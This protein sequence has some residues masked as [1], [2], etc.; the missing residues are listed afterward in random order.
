MVTR[1]QSAQVERWR[2][3]VALSE[4]QLVFRNHRAPDVL[5]QGV[6]EEPPHR[7]S[8]NQESDLSAEY[9]LRQLVTVAP[10]WRLAAT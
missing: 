8:A 7:V 1:K 9:Q 3:D 4:G 10:K 6:E 2:L 5:A